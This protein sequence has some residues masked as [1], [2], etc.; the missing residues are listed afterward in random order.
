MKAVPVERDSL[1][2]VKSL[3]WGYGNRSSKGEGNIVKKE[4]PLG[5]E[6]SNSPRNGWAHIMCF[7]SKPTALGGRV[8]CKFSLPWVGVWFLFSCIGETVTI[9]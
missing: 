3:G 2:F 1:P 6:R 7:I 9:V 8:P 5:E 4:G